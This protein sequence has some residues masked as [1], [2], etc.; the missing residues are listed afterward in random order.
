MHRYR[1]T[2]VQ[3]YRGTEVQRCRCRGAAVQRCRGAEVQRC[4]SAEVQRCRVGAG[5]A[6]K[7][8][9]LLYKGAK[10]VKRR[11]RGGAEAV[12][13]RCRDAVTVQRFITGDYAA[14]GAE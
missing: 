13:S 7:K 1:G 12:Q 5:A 14:E 8:V 2:E 3:R 11:C 4:R 9:Q 6:G 10:E